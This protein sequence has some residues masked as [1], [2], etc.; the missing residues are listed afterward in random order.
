[1]LF[2]STTPHGDFP[3]IRSG[4]IIYES[5]RRRDC[6]EILGDRRRG[7]P[8]DGDLAAVFGWFENGGVCIHLHSLRP[9]C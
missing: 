2:E 1:M 9:R 7:I 5:M 8:Q 6:G 3:E 4:V